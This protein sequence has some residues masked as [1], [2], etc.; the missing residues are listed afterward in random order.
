MSTDPAVLAATRAA[1]KDYDA[2]PGRPLTAE[3]A[4]E[5]CRLLPGPRARED[6]A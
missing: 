5:M 3:A 6:A 4:A 1:D 2:R